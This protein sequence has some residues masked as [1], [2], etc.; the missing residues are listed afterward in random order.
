MASNGDNEILASVSA[1]LEIVAG[2]S[3]GIGLE[4]G[5]SSA[6]NLISSSADMTS[7]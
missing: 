2:Q 7:D 4:A 3:F 5:R 6:V 1:Y